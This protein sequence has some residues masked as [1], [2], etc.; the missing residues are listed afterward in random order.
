MKKTQILIYLIIL[1]F[2]IVGCSRKDN[3]IS[4]ESSITFTPTNTSTTPINSPTITYTPGV[5]NGTLNLP[6]SAEGKNYYIYLFDIFT[7][8]SNADASVSGVCS[9]GTSVSYSII[10]PPGSYYLVVFIDTDNNGVLLSPNAGDYVGV[11][12]ATWPN[13]PA[14]ANVTISEGGVL[15]CDIDLV[16]GFNNV[17]GTIT[18]YPYVQTSNKFSYIFIDTDSDPSNSNS[19]VNGTVFIL[20]GVQDIDYSLLVLVPGIY[21]LYAI[22][23]MDD[24]GTFNSGDQRGYYGVCSPCS[25]Y[26][27]SPPPS[28]NAYITNLSNINN[29]GFNLGIIP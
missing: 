14:N 15:N 2:I 17:M 21:Y 18:L 22:V 19:V 10:A 24:S 26:N 7:S 27:P 5:I 13:W 28:P 1:F 20:G 16:T 25:G 12:G 11:Y 8:F 4:P 29:Y 3:P 9:S 23:D 6:A